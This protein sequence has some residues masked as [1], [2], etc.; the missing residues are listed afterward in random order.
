M[1]GPAARVEALVRRERWW[2]AGL[3]ALVTCCRI[4][5]VDGWDEAFYVGQ[6]LSIVQDRDLRLQDDVVLV[7]K[8]LEEKQR[9]LT[10]ESPSGALANTFSIGPAVLLAPFA[11]PFLPS[12]PDEG[13]WRAF[14]GAAALDAMAMVIVA[15]LLTSLSVRR[16]GVPPG[17]ASLATGLAIVCGPLAVYATRSCLNT[18]LGSALLVALA[19]H[20]ALCWLEGRRLPNAVAFGLAAGLACANRW[21]DVAVIAPLALGV[22]AASGRKGGASWAA[23][24]LAAAAAVVG[25]AVQAMA[26]QVQFGTPLLVPQGP[27]YMHWLDPKPFHLAFSTF[28]GLVPWTPGY[29]LGLVA[30]AIL[31]FGRRK[32][33]PGPRPVLVALAIGSLLAIYVSACPTDWWGG[34]SFGPR[35]LTSLLAPAAVGL[36]MVLQRCSRRSRALLSIVLGSWAIVAVSAHVS[37]FEDMAM[38][39]GGRPGTLLP[40]RIDATPPTA[41]A[42]W[43]SSWRAVHFAVPGFS[44]SDAPRPGDRV[45]GI[46]LVIAVVAVLRC[47]LPFIQRSH[48]AQAGLVAGGL[49]YLLGWNAVLARCPS[50]A[51]WNDQWREF[52][53]APLDESRLA[54]LPSDMALPGHVV[55]AFRAAKER[56]REALATA[57][58]ALRERQLMVSERDIVDAATNPRLPYP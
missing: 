58:A 2:L 14:R 24:G 5:T 38:L 10:T 49:V 39:L 52:L 15:A 28:H 40:E 50:N 30:L 4:P 45:V 56:D 23:I 46:L 25:A 32:P 35:R 11:A 8:R 54:A 26:W 51:G 36:G 57:V 17:V 44:L 19:L 27:A 20:Q 12:L 34:A 21:Q 47:V 37:G 53:A 29:A 3:V 33:L 43:A 6:L 31:A 9:I 13:G 41:A 7:P 48:A 22:L 18:H 42:R 1:N 16:F 55:A